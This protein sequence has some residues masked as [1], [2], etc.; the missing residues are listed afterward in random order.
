MGDKAP[1]L[2]HRRAAEAFVDGRK[3]KTICGKTV[4][5]FDADFG[6]RHVTC[7]ICKQLNP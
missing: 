6:A 1:P 7:P 5:F 2:V 4:V 3:V